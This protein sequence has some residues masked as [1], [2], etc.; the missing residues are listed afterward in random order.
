[1]DKVYLVDGRLQGR[2]VRDLPIP[3]NHGVSTLSRLTSWYRNDVLSA[4]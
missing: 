1:M 3:Q 4:V 2:D